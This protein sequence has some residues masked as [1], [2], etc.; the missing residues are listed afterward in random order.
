MNIS[1]IDDII[2]ACASARSQLGYKASVTTKGA[3]VWHSL[4]QAAGSPGAFATPAAASA[5]G[6]VPDRTTAGAWPHVNA[7]AG[8]DATL[9]RFGGQIAN[10]GVLR[11]YDRL[12]ACSGLS[13]T[14]T[15]SQPITSPPALTRPDANGVGAELWLEVYAALGG[16]ATGVLTATYVNQAGTGSR[17]ATLDLAKYAALNTAGTMAP[18]TLQAGDTGVRSVSAVVNTVS[19]GTAGDFG[20]TILRGVAT[21]SLDTAGS[22]RDLDV[23]RL[24]APQV[25]DGACLAFMLL[26]S[27]TSSGLLDMWTTVAD[28]PE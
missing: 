25:Y 12:W 16:T 27:T 15:S 18:F 23:T 5:G 22:S 14:L 1:S 2:A 9:F 19:T 13:G 7:A 24:L 8:K 11:L 26:C 4:A 10:P 6:A 28:V 17:S 21:L 3:G 20:L